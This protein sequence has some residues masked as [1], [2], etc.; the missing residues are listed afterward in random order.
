MANGSER[1]VLEKGS[2]VARKVVGERLRHGTAYYGD[3]QDDGKA[4]NLPVCVSERL[5]EK[6]EVVAHGMREM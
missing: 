5:G 3:V 1:V 4:P 6:H 2:I